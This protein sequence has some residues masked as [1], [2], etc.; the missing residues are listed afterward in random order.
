M[1]A[2][3]VAPLVGAAAAT[4]TYALIES[5]EAAQMRRRPAAWTRPEEPPQL[6]R[7]RRRQLDSQEPGP[8]PRVRIL[9]PAV[10][11]VGLYILG[12][13]YSGG[14]VVALYALGDGLHRWSDG[15]LSGVTDAVKRLLLYPIVAAMA[16]GV[17]AIPGLVLMFVGD[18]LAPTESGTAT[19][20]ER[21]SVASGS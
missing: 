11:R 12:V 3:V 7:I 15:Q 6:R 14:L 5:G 13:A 19:D 17:A 1:A 21:D 20:P 16:G 18:A 9:G 4:G 2:P 10:E 8:S